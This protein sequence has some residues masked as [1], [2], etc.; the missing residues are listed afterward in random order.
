MLAHSKIKPNRRDFLGVKTLK[1][2]RGT[3]KTNSETNL[4]CI[5]KGRL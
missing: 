1:V 4:M 5:V 2:K 3:R